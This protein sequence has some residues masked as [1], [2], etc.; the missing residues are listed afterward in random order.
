MAPKYH[1]SLTRN[2]KHLASVSLPKALNDFDY[3]FFEQRST[4]LDLLAAMMN[5]PV[6]ADQRELFELWSV[7]REVLERNSYP[8]DLSYTYSISS[9][10]LALEYY[11]RAVAVKDRNGVL[12]VCSLIVQDLR[13]LAKALKTRKMETAVRL[14]PSLVRKFY[15]LGGAERDD[16][17]FAGYSRTEPG[18]SAKKAKK[19][20]NIDKAIVMAKEMKKDNPRLT[21]SAMYGKIA[22]NMDCA[23]STVKAYLNKVKI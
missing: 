19:E 17:Y 21:K 6:G 1:R 12:Y 4:N 10:N 5:E 18:A 23:Q 22:K 9:Y 16:N 11:I 2:R 13:S 14:Y 8:V 20:G 7:V 15:L 3:A